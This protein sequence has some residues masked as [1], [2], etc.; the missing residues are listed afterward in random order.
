MEQHKPS[1]SE[2]QLAEPQPPAETQRRS[3]QLDYYRLFES[4]KDKPCHVV[5]VKKLY[6]E[7]EPPLRT[8]EHIID[9]EL[10]R[11][12]DAQTL[13]EIYDALDVACKH[14]EALDVFNGIE[15]VITEEP[16]D[17]PSGCSIELNVREKKWYQIRASTYV[18][19]NEGGCEATL[20]LRNLR[21]NGESL[22]CTYD[23]GVHNS[24]QFSL[25]YRHPLPRGLPITWQSR[26]FQYFH[27]YQKTSSYTEAL[28]GVSAG[29]SSL[30]NSKSLQYELGWRQISDPTVRASRAIAAQCGDFLKSSLRYSVIADRRDSPVLPTEGWMARSSSEVGGLAPDASR[31]VKQQVDVQRATALGPDTSFTL[32]A[33]A[34]VLVPLG[35]GSC[36][37]DRFF[38]GG[39]GTL[40]GFQY[41]GAGPADQQR[42]RQSQAVDAQSQTVDNTPAYD[43]LGG[44][45]YANILA[46]VTVLLPHPALA[47][48]RLH[49][50]AFLNGGNVTGLPGLAGGAGWRGGALGKSLHEFATTFRWSAGLG[51]VLPTFFG[52]FE[53]N[54]CWLLSSQPT[55]RTQ[56]GI[57]IG[58][59]T[60]AFP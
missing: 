13:E 38:L 51:L 47:A 55:D 48:L 30:D 33:T 35:G 50:H 29:I 11:V 15:A 25:L 34:G 12:Q 23:Y 3:P 37:T 9:R 4:V 58:F 60:S 1:A 7:Q 14:L 26:L 8:N 6:L 44:D 31:F 19:G 45:L 27:N 28:R 49:G 46:A 42:P 16:Q 20:H 36:V 22:S 10:A 39:P 40:R 18:Q 43:A 59:A 54:Y 24:N 32:T 2:A 57:Q 5:T 41:L 53:A 52:R 17:D 56:P 21:G